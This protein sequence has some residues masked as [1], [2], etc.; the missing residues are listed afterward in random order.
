MYNRHS[1]KIA[2]VLQFSSFRKYLQVSQSRGLDARTHPW[3]SS[4]Q[5]RCFHLHTHARHNVINRCKK[6]SL[7][8]SK[9]AITSLDSSARQYSLSSGHSQREYY[10]NCQCAHSILIYIHKQIAK[11]SERALIKCNVHSGL[12]HTGQRKQM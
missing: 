12:L 11:V 7:P 9:Y 8:Q 1:W 3:Q 6:L 4:A 2:I 5:T 10:N